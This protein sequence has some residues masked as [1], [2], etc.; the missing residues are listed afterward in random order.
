M[1][2]PLV[3]AALATLLAGGT[4]L[5]EPNFNRIATIQIPATIK[6]RAGWR[7][8]GAPAMG[9]NSGTLRMV[10]IRRPGASRRRRRCV[11]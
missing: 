3:L 5:G 2:K 10:P 8:V 1:R 9:P 11:S 4:A 6:D 7:S